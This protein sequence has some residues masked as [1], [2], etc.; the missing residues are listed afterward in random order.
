MSDILEVLDFFGAEYAGGD[1]HWFADEVEVYCPFC[2]DA[3]SHRPAG[4]VNP[5]KN[6]YYC[7]ACGAGGGPAS[8]V[9]RFT[10]IEVT[11]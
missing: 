11:R 7:F 4:R 5:L 8:L 10:T 9:D 1:H 6:V 3:H 2:E